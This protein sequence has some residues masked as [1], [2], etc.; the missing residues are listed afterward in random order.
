[1]PNETITDKTERT[2]IQ[3]TTISEFN[4]NDDKWK[5]WKQRLGIHFAEINCTDENAILL[6]SVG[7]PALE[8]L[9]NLCDPIEPMKK[10]FTELLDILDEHYTPPTIVYH[11]RK[12]FHD[13]IRDDSESVSAWYARIKKLALQCKYGTDLDVMVKDK[14]ITQLPEKIFTRLCEED[15]KLTLAN[16]FKKSL[17]LET[18][19]AL[20]KEGTDSDVNLVRLPRANQNQRN[21]NSS[22]NNNNSSKQ[23]HGKKTACTRCGWKTHEANNCA[24]KEAT[25]HSCSKKG[26]LSTVC[27]NKNKKN[28]NFIDPNSNND[29]SV[30]YVNSFSDGNLFDFRL[31]SL[32]DDESKELYWL[33]VVFGGTEMDIA[34]DTGAPRTFVPRTFY[35]KHLSQYPLTKCNIPYRNY[36]GIKIDLI[37]ECLPSITYSGTN[38]RITVVVTDANAPPLLGR[39]FLRAFGFLLVQSNPNNEIHVHSIESETQ[40]FP[41]IVNQI[42]S[43]FSDLF[44]GQL[45]KYNVC[46][47]S[48]QI[49]SDAK[50]IFCKPRS[51][52][53]AWKSEIEQ[54]LRDLVANGVLEQVETSKL[55]TTVVPVPKPDGK[56][57]VCGDYKTT[58]NK[59]LV[60]VKYPLP[61]I[62]EIFTSL[63]GGELFSKLDMSAAYN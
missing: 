60:D 32:A 16:A 25:C 62:E 46:E 3:S 27:R 18:K 11:E 35:E 43:E 44:D 59:F 50:P 58:L 53:I 41:I 20:R 61:L 15:E 14:F 37:G 34:C 39:N 2:V 9:T 52:P 13:A 4:V 49:D 23:P 8:L 42:K 47:V 55:G 38:R 28:F 33:K 40:H 12:I 10:E 51:I 7:T 45:G 5:I 19:F 1:M 57:R 56:L 21:R 26:H 54:N 30:S 22:N 36:G 6:K 48:L 63:Q 29:N 24:Y 31:Y 17:I